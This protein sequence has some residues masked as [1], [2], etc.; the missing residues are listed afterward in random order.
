MDERQ[1]AKD[2]LKKEYLKEI[3]SELVKEEVVREGVIEIDQ[4]GE[5]QFFGHNPDHLY[6]VVRALFDKLANTKAELWLQ[7]Q[8]VKKS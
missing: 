5:V 7:N 6:A 3:V 8:S 2:A 1:I 4:R